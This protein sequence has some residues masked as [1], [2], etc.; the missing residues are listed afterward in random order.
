MASPCTEARPSPV[1]L[2]RLGL[3]VKKGSAARATSA[4][5]VHAGSRRRTTSMRR[6]AALATGPCAGQDRGPR[7]ARRAMLPTP[8]MASRAF[9]TRLSRARTS[10]SGID[11]H[12][13][14]ANVL[15]PRST[16]RRRI[17]G[18]SER[19]ASSTAVVD[20]R[21]DP[22]RRRC[23][24]QVLAPARTPAGAAPGCARGRRPAGPTAMT[25]CASA[26]RSAGRSA[27]SP[28]PPSPGSAGC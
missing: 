14:A 18:R 6:I 5:P 10:W 8:G 12:G 2:A 1:P 11:P 23:G 19:W 15:R 20:Q 21:V 26:R 28:A 24:C 4:V 16:A 13:P 7:A 27:R 22:L 25:S 3:V 17:P 9:T